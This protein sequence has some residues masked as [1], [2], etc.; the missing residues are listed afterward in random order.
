MAKVLTIPE[1]EKLKLTY[2]EEGD[3]LYMSFGEPKEATDSVDLDG[4]IYRYRREMLIGITVLGFRKRA[5][6]KLK[7]DI[8][9][10]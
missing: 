1:A 9:P 5:E 10:P 2:D 3:V 8:K 4:I 6:S 7:N